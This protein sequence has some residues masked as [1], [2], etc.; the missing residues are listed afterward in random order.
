VPYLVDGSNLGGRLGGAA[1]A[2]DRAA[3]LRLL[4]QWT[5]GGGT[6][7]APR[8]RVLV[9]FDGPEDAALATAYGPLRVRFSGARPADAVILDELGNSAA[10][11]WVVSADRALIAACRARGAQAVDPDEILGTQARAPA[12]AVDETSRHD[13]RVDVAEWEAWFRRGGEEGGEG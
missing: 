12:P 5:R 8:R 4:L 9:V 10:D 3:V 1:G 2:R 7:R 11:W 13:G 6:A